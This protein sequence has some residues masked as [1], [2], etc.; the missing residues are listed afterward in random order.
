MTYHICIDHVISIKLL[1]VQVKT[2]KKVVLDVL[3][4]TNC[5]ITIK[6]YIEILWTYSFLEEFEFY[7]L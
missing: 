1:C 5:T 2:Q 7:N 3:S 4:L 6:S